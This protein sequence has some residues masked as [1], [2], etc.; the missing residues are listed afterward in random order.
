MCLF[1][2]KYYWLIDWLIDNLFDSVLL[3]YFPAFDDQYYAC[4]ITI[5]IIFSAIDGE[6][7]GDWEVKLY[8][9]VT[10]TIMFISQVL[11]LIAV[12]HYCFSDSILG[13]CVQQA[14]KLFCYFVT[15]RV[16]DSMEYLINCVEYS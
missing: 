4:D 13:N 1:S 3:W 16:R 6:R 8:S 5:T 9:T 14:F 7:H 15:Y 11:S 2:L 10:L 12:T